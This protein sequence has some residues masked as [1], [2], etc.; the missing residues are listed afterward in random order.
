MCVRTY[1]YRFF[2]LYKPWKVFSVWKTG[3][4]RGKMIAAGAALTKNLF[5]FNTPLRNALFVVRELS[6]PLTSLGMLSIPYKDTFD[7]HD[8]ITAQAKGMLIKKESYVFILHLPLNLS[9]D[10]LTHL[11][12]IF[13]NFYLLV[14]N[15]L[16]LTLLHIIKF[17][18]YHISFI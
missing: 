7:I 9:F 15:F 17:M 8:F 11:F 3:L 5:L 16:C 18:F 13:F 1:V 6:G 12:D 2:K 10:I 14:L 4:K